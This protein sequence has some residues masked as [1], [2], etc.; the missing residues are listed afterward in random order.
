M[1][2]RSAFRNE[3]DFTVA[4]LETMGSPVQGRIVGRMVDNDASVSDNYKR[5]IMETV[6]LV[7]SPD[8]SRERT[9]GQIEEDLIGEV[10]RALARIFPELRFDGV[11]GVGAQGPT[12][13]FLFTKGESKNFLYKNLSG[14][15]KAAFD[16]LLDVIVKRKYF[17]PALWCIDEPE[18]HMGTRA[19]GRLLDELVRLV[20]EESQLFIASHSIGFMTRAV[21]MARDCP[22]SVAFLDLGGH[23]FDHAVTLTPVEPNREFWRRTLDVALDDLA[24][25]VGPKQVVMCEGR[26]SRKSRNADFDAEC[27]RTIFAQEFPDTDFL[28]VGN[29]HDASNDTIG[30]ASALQTLSRGTSVVRLV[31]RDMRTPHEVNELQ[32]A[33]VRVLTLRHI[34]SYLYHDEVLA[35]LC[36]SVGQPDK[37]PEV[38]AL[39]AAKLQAS[40]DRGNDAD[41]MKSAAGEL[42]TAVRQLL[43]LTQAGSHQAA[44]ARDTLAPLL[45]PEMEA[46]RLLKSDIFGGET[47]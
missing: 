16:L 42:Y 22:G 47:E 32:A 13:T 33:G 15:E 9:V 41:D 11:T 27:Y 37:S 3:A 6:G 29:S 35:A 2:Q 14:G 10:R 8:V 40:V 44:F 46:Y 28:S 31:D 4:Q 1:Y 25:L 7:F 39:K 24:D 12:G 21:Q 20:P 45:R 36:A 43:G 17:N 18:A 34:E 38:V 26:P 19:Q 23:D 5:L 30:L